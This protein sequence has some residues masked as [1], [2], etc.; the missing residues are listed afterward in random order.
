[1]EPLEYKNNYNRGIKHPN[2]NQVE[3]IQGKNN[4]PISWLN[5]QA[6]CEY[7]IYLENFKHLKVKANKAMING[8]KVHNKLE[9]NFKKE[10]EVA[11]LHDILETSKEK[12]VISREFFV[13]SENYGIRGFIDEIW[14]TP[15]SI[16]IIDDKPGARAYN[17][18]INQVFAYC[19]A[20]KDRLNDDRRIE[21]AL[22][23]RGTSNIFWQKEFDEKAEE[24]IIETIN[25]M[26]RLIDG[27]DEFIPTKNPNKCN[28]CRFKKLCTKSSC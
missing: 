7:S 13:I 16:V 28:A 11:S 24:N 19:L 26:Q 18:M 21:G 10:A 6:Y 4:F 25:H 2:I 14:L 22:R 1:M 12:E 17:S 15:E 20:Y 27:E 8:S 23:T 5:T 9:S 3:I